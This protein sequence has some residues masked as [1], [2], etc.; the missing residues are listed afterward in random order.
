MS[1][2]DLLKIG[3]TTD[4]FTDHHLEWPSTG[5]VEFKPKHVHAR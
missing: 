4:L 1:L 2:P 3:V 5:H